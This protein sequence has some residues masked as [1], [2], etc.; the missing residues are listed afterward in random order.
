MQHPRVIALLLTLATLAVYAQ[1]ASFEFAGLDDDVYVYRNAHLV[2]GVGWDDVLS[3]FEFGR[4]TANW[5][6]LTSLSLTLDDFPSCRENLL[7]DLGRL[8][9]LDMLS[10]FLGC[11]N[12]QHGGHERC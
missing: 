12:F 6:P 7:P 1:T 10:I 11:C 8:K 3:S 9:V 5:H 4:Q 2:D